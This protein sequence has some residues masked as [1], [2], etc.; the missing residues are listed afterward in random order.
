MNPR[1]S[2][3]D[4]SKMR[5]HLGTELGNK[6]TDTFTSIK[7]KEGNKVVFTVKQLDARGKDVPDWKFEITDDA[8][9]L[10]I[11]RIIGEVA[12]EPRV[13]GVKADKPE[14]IKQWLQD[15]QGEIDWPATGQ[16]IK[17][18]FKKQGGVK[19]G[20]R[21]QADIRIAIDEKFIVPQDHIEFAHGQRTPKYYIN[22]QLICPF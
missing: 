11:P 17:E 22:Q 12:E 16:E 3:D 2:N 6:V 14:D 10:G 21:L 1:P 4:E 18:I 19:R 7:K 15:G 13:N 8:G 9:E 5:G 20:E